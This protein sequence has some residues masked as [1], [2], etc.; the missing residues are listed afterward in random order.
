MKKRYCVMCKKDISHLHNRSVRCGRCQK[1]I[2]R[3]QNNSA[4]RARKNP[5]YRKVTNRYVVIKSIVDKIEAGELNINIR[6][7]TYDSL[8]ALYIYLRKVEELK[9][10]NKE[11]LG[12]SYLE[13]MEKELKRLENKP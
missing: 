10:F 13:W 8:Y 2:R 4:R 5:T 7:W 11:V 6:E 3:Y 1:E 12:D 9:K